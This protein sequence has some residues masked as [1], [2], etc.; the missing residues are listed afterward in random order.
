ML[1]GTRGTQLHSQASAVRIRL[2]TISMHTPGRCTSSRLAI[3][4]GNHAVGVRDV[5]VATR[6]RL[7]GGRCGLGRGGKRRRRLGRRHS[8]SA[9]RH[10]LPI[11][12]AGGRCRG[13]GASCGSAGGLLGGP[14]TRTR[15]SPMHAA[16]GKWL[17]RMRLVQPVTSCC[18]M[19]AYASSG[20]HNTSC[21]H[22]QAMLQSGVGKHYRERVRQRRSHASISVAA[23]TCEPDLG[24]NPRF[25]ALAAP[26]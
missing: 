14:V 20:L 13:R 18:I 2:A 19:L 25:G 26:E 23:S 11:V 24:L 3:A 21:M 17:H 15:R 8:G 6:A 4:L 22:A 7:A 12:A 9:D 1:P 16:M 5:G 10:G